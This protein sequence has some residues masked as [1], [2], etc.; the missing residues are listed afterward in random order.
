MQPSKAKQ[1]DAALP[2]RES[3]DNPDQGTLVY[4]VAKNSKRRKKKREE[5]NTD[6]TIVPVIAAH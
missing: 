3:I 5:K 6:R 2:R 1:N 4:V